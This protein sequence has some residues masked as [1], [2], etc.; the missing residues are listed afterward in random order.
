MVKWYLY[1]VQ[2]IAQMV[3]GQSLILGRR[4]SQQDSCQSQTYNSTHKHPHSMAAHTPVP[5]VFSLSPQAPKH[6]YTV[7][8]HIFTHFSILTLSKRE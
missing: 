2:V 4:G 5:S 8:T 7:H 6:V 3:C 1:C